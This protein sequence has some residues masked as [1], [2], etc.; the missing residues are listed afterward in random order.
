M[1]KEYLKIV[2]ELKPELFIIEN[3]KGLLIS[4]DGFFKKEIIRSIKKLGYFVEYGVL[5]AADF[6]VP[7]SRERTIFICS[8]KRPIPL[9]KQE[10]FKRTTVRDAIEDLAFLNS[11][12]GEFVQDYKYLAKS[13]YQMLRRRKSYK[14]YNHVASKHKDV[15][16]KK[17]MLIPPEQG[18]EFLPKELTGKQKYK[19]TW[20]RLKW[21]DI[22]PT[23]DTRFDAASN[24]TNNHPFLNRAITPREAARLQSFDDTFVF[25]GS[26]VHVRKQIGNAVP[27]LLAK[28]IADQ[29]EKFYK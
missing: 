13:E 17:L 21:Y 8:K 6:G 4:S 11:G 16:I 14:L 20:G 12:E 7:Q 15:A 24:G 26:K 5:N 28:A 3:V 18:K 10:I 25:L 2:E 9:P 23:I 19:T 27:P 22:S 1:F 29:I